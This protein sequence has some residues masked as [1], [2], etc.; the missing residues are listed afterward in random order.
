M[1]D[2]SKIELNGTEMIM[3]PS[4]EAL[5]N[6]ENSLNMSIVKLFSTIND[7]NIGITQMIEIVFHGLEA[8]GNPLSRDEIKAAMGKVGWAKFFTPIISF[9]VL[10]MNGPLEEDP[11]KQSTPTA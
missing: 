4:I 3:R 7:Q 9:L 10:S 5:I 1:I 6:I 2:I 11:M 8:G